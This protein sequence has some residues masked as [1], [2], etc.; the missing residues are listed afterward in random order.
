MLTKEFSET[1]QACLQDDQEFAIALFNEAIAGLFN[2]EPELTRLILRDLVNATIG[3]EALATLTDRP[4]KSLHR[5]LSP[6]G[7]PTMDNLTL[8]LR[9]LQEKLNIQISIQTTVHL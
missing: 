7:N 8:I 9:T 1:V 2:G 4:S 6:S 5:M 3:F